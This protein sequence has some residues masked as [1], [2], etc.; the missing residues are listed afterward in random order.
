MNDDE[1]LH[2]LTDAFAPEPCAPP[3]I[4]LQALHQSIDAARTTPRPSRRPRRRWLLPAVAT[5]SVLGMGNLALATAGTTLPQ[6]FR[7]AAYEVH[8][9]VDSA[10]MIETRHNFHDLRA[11]LD[12]DDLAAVDEQMRLLRTSFDRLDVDERR[13][14][15][16]EVLEIFGQAQARLALVDDKSTTDTPVPTTTPPG[17]DPGDTPEPAGPKPTNDSDAPDEANDGG[18]VPA[19]R[20]V[21][22][23]P[24]TPE[25]HD[26]TRSRDTSSSVD[27]HDTET[28]D[29]AGVADG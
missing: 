28:L 26:A 12:R 24:D 27:G 22:P 1:L 29:A 15:A 11:A 20:I 7:A 9:S 21:N 19:T 14:I 6:V 23:T 18:A 2:R 17:T 4:G 16:A 5:V 25:D 3:A 8:L 10:A 13:S